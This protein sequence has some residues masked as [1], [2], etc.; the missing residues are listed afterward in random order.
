MKASRLY[1]HFTPHASRDA[2]L[3]LDLIGRARPRSRTRLRGQ[4][5]FSLRVLGS[6]SKIRMVLGIS[7]ARLR[8][9]D[10]AMIWSI[11]LTGWL[12][13]CF[14][15]SLDPGLVSPTTPILWLLLS[16]FLVHAFS[17]HWEETC[18]IFIAP[19]LS[20]YP[21]FLFNFMAA[22]CFHFSAKFTAVSRH[23]SPR[24]GLLRLTTGRRFVLFFDSL[25]LLV[26]LCCKL[27]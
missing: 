4:K 21:R 3:G 22:L 6:A 10:R 7:R 13:G 20:C 1:S 17:A 18:Y 27:V 16:Y 12:L 14:F 23:C 26:G 11:S 25:D 24:H 9:R 5:T 19:F 2:R 15:S 8:K